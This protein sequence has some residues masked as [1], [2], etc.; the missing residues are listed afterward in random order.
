MSLL[1]IRHR[2]F[3][4]L[5]RTNCWMDALLCTIQLC[6]AQ[7]NL[8]W[9]W[10]GLFTIFWV[11]GASTDLSECVGL[12]Q[13]YHFNHIC[14]DGLVLHHPN[15]LKE[16]KRRQ[17]GV[18]LNH[19]NCMWTNDIQH[20]VH[21]LSGSTPSTIINTVDTATPVHTVELY[22]TLHPFNSLS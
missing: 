1:N 4:R 22:T 14:C 16:W 11:T 19:Y 21:T 3:Q 20:L 13:I 10:N 6:D 5:L 2:S 7:I 12:N 18:P 8:K 15:C 17:H 9:I